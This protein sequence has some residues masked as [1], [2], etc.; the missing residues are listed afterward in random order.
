MTIKATNTPL[1]AILPSD[2]KSLKKWKRPCV[3]PP[4]SLS[5]LEISGPISITLIYLSNLQRTS[6]EIEIDGVK[7]CLLWITQT[8]HSLPLVATDGS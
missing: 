7:S 1:Q 8:N 5:I 3:A 4:A 2:Q 6:K